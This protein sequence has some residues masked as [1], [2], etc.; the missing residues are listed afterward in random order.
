ML[1]TTVARPVAYT[2]VGLHSGKDVQIKL[3]P[4][5]VDSGIVFHVHTPTGIRRITPRPDAVCATA[6]ATTL[7]DGQTRVST[8]EHALAALSGMGVDNVQVHVTGGEIPIMDGSAAELVALIERAGLRTQHMPR[9]VARVRRPL[10]VAGDGK[11]IHAW[12]HK[13]FYVDYTIDF[14][15]AAIGRQRLA[16]EINPHTFA[17]RASARTFGFLQEV[18]YLHSKGLALG[19]SLNNAVV[20]D[21]HGVVNPEGLRCPDEFVRHKI[22]DFV[23]D[24]AMLGLPLQGAFEVHC[25]GHQHNNAFLRRL[26]EDGDYLQILSLDCESGPSYTDA[27]FPV[28][29]VPA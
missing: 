21:E 14:P 26:L 22:L 2:G 24:M 18:E 13:G 1:Q 6:L 7:S 12:P 10:T 28:M 3:Q 19:G 17:E 5:P 29:V 11:A 15:H 4:A 23:G 20:L 16:L 25:S 9:R 27:S 8:V